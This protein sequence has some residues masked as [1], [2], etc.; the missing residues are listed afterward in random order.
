M[1]EIIEL[2]SLESIETPSSLQNLN[3]QQYLIDACLTG[4]KQLCHTFV[5]SHLFQRTS[6]E[7]SV[8][9]GEELKVSTKVDIDKA[10]A[11]MFYSSNEKR[12]QIN[13][14]N[15]AE[16]GV[17][18]I[19]MR[20]DCMSYLHSFQILNKLLIKI[21]IFPRESAAHRNA[22]SSTRDGL[23]IAWKSDEER[24]KVIKSLTEE[25]EDW[26]KDLFVIS[27]LSS[28]SNIKS[29]KLF[30]LDKNEICRL[31]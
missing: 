31:I 11:S 12:I 13:I 14:K 3:N 16:L 26:V 23:N 4:L 17:H 2:N 20:S 28:L 27:C 22:A 10:F 21:L 8:L 24:N 7:I 29:I 19:S 9:S 6:S 5:V 15:G 30:R 18:V 1:I 25:F